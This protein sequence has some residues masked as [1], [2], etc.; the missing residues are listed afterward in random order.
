MRLRAIVVRPGAENDIHKRA[1]LLRRDSVHGRFAGSIK[2]DKE[3]GAL[4]ANGHFI[5]IIYA[6]APDQIDYEAH[7]IFRCDRHRQHRQW[8][9]REGLGLHLAAKGVSK[10]LLTAPGKGDMKNV[11]ASASTMT[12][13]RDNEH[14]HLRRFSCTTNAIVPPLKAL[15]DEEYGIEQRSR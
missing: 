6:N 5:K 11:V 4:I 1:S 8:R 2:I 7:G 10:A 12:L 15:M 13:L 3:N 9:D 14:H